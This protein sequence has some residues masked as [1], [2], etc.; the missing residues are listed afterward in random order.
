MMVKLSL[1]F[2][3]CFNEEM[4]IYELL[5]VLKKYIEHFFL[6]RIILNIKH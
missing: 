2:Y 3:I 1:L 5:F 4:Q 6:F